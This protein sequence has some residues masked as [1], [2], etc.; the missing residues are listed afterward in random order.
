MVL[1]LQM[2]ALLCEEFLGLLISHIVLPDDMIVSVPCSLIHSL[3]V[4][5]NRK[6]CHDTNILVKY[7]CKET[8]FQ[9]KLGSE[10]V[11]YPR[12]CSV[13]QLL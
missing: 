10:A 2:F 3:E 12:P 6:K 7:P 11:Y 5:I 9:E 13:K 1:P 8:P 4:A